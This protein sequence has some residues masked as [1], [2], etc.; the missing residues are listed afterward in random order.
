MK[1]TS[2]SPELEKR[3]VGEFPHLFADYG[4]PAEETCMAWGC[5][6]GDGW[7]PI[8]LGLCECIDLRV[9]HRGIEFRFAQI[10]EKFGTLR[11]YCYG[12]DDYIDGAIRMAEEMS[13]VTCEITG[14]VGQLCKSG[15]WYRTLSSEMAAV[16]G[17]EVCSKKKEEESVEGD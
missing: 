4:K 15:Y 11:V 8:I 7:F 10:K 5:E 2:V 17:Y 1:E 6:H 14:S 3:L 9:K 16:H 12:S 13:S